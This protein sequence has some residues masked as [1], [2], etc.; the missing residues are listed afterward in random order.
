ME[1]LKEIIPLIIS[2]YEKN[3]KDLPWR[4]DAD[5]YAIW[6]SE[7]MLQQTRI[8][9]VIPYYH[10]FLYELPHVRALAE[11]EDDRL[12][13][14]WE[15]LGY[16][17]RARNLKKAAGLLVSEYG[18]VFPKTAGE[19][20]KL[21]GIGDYTAGAIASIAFGEPEPAV[22]G[23]VLRV[24]SRVAASAEDIALL[25]TKRAVSELLRSV[26]P[27]GKEAGML[28]E[29]LM[30]LGETVCLPNGTP[31]CDSCPL[32]DKCTACLTGSVD[33]YPVK[34]VKKA[35]REEEKT[36]FLIHDGKC[37]TYAL[38]KRPKTGLLAD[39]WEFPNVSGH[40][41]ED[42]VKAKVEDM[43]FSVGSIRFLG[44]ARHVF[45]HVEWDMVVY[46]IVVGSCEGKL[47][48]ET[49]E[50]IRRNYAVPSAFRFSLESMK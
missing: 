46:E 33:R 22:D 20:R 9:A 48:F 45:S 50:Q 3:K 43:G 47:L 12:M 44:S 8:E 38:R 24:Y 4:R 26:Y 7:I 18:G 31:L 40:L 28:T 14:L 13:K 36:V 21:P 39:M 34:S 16:Y 19:L 10:R 30:E 42:A 1:V 6:I 5:P 29:G 15:G 25:S 17:S 49:A 23:N 32:W 41:S 35:R 37:G 27:T 2:W 11:C